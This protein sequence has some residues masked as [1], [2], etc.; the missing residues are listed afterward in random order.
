MTKEL[1]SQTLII[2]APM[3]QA[4]TLDPHIGTHKT[5]ALTIAMSLSMPGETVDVNAAF[6]SITPI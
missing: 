4:R 5:D 3:R 1:A 6:S 2:S